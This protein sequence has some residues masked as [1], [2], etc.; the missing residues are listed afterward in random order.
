MFD[1]MTVTGV[2]GLGY[3]GLAGREGVA[4]LENLTTNYDATLIVT[5]HDGVD[6]ATMFSHA[7]FVVNTRNACRKAGVADASI[8]QRLSRNAP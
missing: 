4:W 2:I 1:N 5:E 6:Y 3:V 8:V 7:P